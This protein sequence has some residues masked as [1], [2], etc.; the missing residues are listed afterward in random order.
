MRILSFIFILISVLSLGITTSY[1]A[2]SNAEDCK[3]IVDDIKTDAATFLKKCGDGTDGYLPS[4]G[5][6]TAT[7]TYVISIATKVIQFGALFAIGAIVFS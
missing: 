3:G 6:V 2:Y 5:G 7:K 1:F 4:G